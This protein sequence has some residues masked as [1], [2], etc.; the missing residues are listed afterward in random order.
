MTWAGRG[1]GPAVPGVERWAGFQPTAALGRSRVSGLTLASA[2]GEQRRWRGGLVAVCAPRGA[3]FEL[4]SHAGAAVAYLPG[5]GYAI[6]ASYDG[7]T[8]VPWL[9]AAGSCTGSLLPFDVH[10]ARAGAALARTGPWLRTL[11]VGLRPC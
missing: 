6:E 1:E 4:G 11:T 7:A 5:R 9:W 10:G 8:N 3:A 2:S